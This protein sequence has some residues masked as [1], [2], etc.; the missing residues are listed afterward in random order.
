MACDANSW[1]PCDAPSKRSMPNSPKVLRQPNP[2]ENTSYLCEAKDSQGQKTRGAAILS[3]ANSI[4]SIKP[5]VRLDR[6]DLQNHSSQHTPHVLPLSNLCSPK[7]LASRKTPWGD[8]NHTVRPSAS[9]HPLGHSKQQWPA[10][11]ANKV[12]VNARTPL[13]KLKKTDSTKPVTALQQSPS[14][15]LQNLQNGMKRQSAELRVGSH[16]SRIKAEK[17]LS[18]GINHHAQDAN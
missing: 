1:E 15:P 2:W 7:I 13:C 3:T 14:S 11:P 4:W 6:L 17:I 8:L 16:G 18:T 12:S 10:N 5:T 9:A